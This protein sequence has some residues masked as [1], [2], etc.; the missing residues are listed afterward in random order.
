MTA[1]QSLWTRANR[2]FDERAPRERALAL[3]IA[4]AAIALLGDHVFLRAADAEL[5]ALRLRETTLTASSAPTS[6]HAVDARALETR[7]KALESDLAK[8]DAALTRLNDELVPANRVK[9]LLEQLLADL[10]GVR[11]TAMHNLSA[12]AL[13]AGSTDPLTNTTL[14]YRHGFEVRL[15][16]NY[17]DLVRYMA[18]VEALPQ[19][20]LWRRVSLD[21]SAY[22]VDRLT[23]VI[24]TLSREST[25]L[26]L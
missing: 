15:Q 25:W 19:R 9:P 22:P 18:R 26:T 11:I 3:M 14:L 7:R 20:V 17:P 21:A 10:P 12:Q 13:D 1:L 24:Y 16:G 23:I 2:G 4:V 8:A 5:R 6:G